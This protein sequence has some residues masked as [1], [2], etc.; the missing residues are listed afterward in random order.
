MGNKFQMLESD[1]DYV[2][3]MKSSAVYTLDYSP[4]VKLNRVT[5]KWRKSSDNCL[6]SHCTE[7]EWFI[8]KEASLLFVCCGCGWT[9]VI[10]WITLEIGGVFLQKWIQESYHG[11]STTF[12]RATDQLEGIGAKKAVFPKK[13]SKPASTCCFLSSKKWTT[14]KSVNRCCSSCLATLRIPGS[15]GQVQE[16][17]GKQEE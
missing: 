6:H 9:E 3:R 5:M 17:L 4:R 8:S 13:R 1:R 14:L 15:N 11:E 2:I 7:M 10:K 16:R 12:P